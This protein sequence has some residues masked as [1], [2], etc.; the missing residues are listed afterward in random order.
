MGS[1]KST[2]NFFWKRV[3]GQEKENL[4]GLAQTACECIDFPWRYRSGHGG[5]T[6]VKLCRLITAAHSRVAA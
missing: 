4:G 1:R 5:S 6:A 3:Y 2:R